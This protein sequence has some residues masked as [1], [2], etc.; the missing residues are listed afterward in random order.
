MRGGGSCFFPLLL[1]LTQPLNPAPRTAHSQ[2]SSRLG[3]RLRTHS[4]R[5]AWRWRALR[6]LRGLA[7]PACC[8]EPCGAPG[9]ENE[10][11]QRDAFGAAN[12]TLYPQ[13]PVW[14]PLVPTYPTPCP[15]HLE[16]ACAG[17]L[18]PPTRPG[19]A[20]REVRIGRRR[21]TQLE[22]PRGEHRRRE[23][24]HLALAAAQGSPR[25]A[26]PTAPLPANERGPRQ[27][28]R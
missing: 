6:P 17:P 26:P 11:F 8:P 16:P 12:L 9:R 21:A 28:L 24:P 19:G 15:R 20:G 18:P 25:A 5:M 3:M 1:P 27:P 23:T 22:G 10:S 7:N 13:Q 14:G 4:A 2:T